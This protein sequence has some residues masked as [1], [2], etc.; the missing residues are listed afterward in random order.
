MID[1]RKLHF[2]FVDIEKRKCRAIADP[3]FESIL[4]K[5]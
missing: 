4:K 2:Q 1:S 5:L 3:A